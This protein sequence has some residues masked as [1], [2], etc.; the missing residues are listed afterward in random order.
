MRTLTAP[1]KNANK[2]NNNN[3]IYSG[4]NYNSFKKNQRNSSRA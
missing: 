4:S 3:S 1:K 2:N